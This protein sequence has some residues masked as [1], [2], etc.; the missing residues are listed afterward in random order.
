VKHEEIWH[1]CDRCGKKIKTLNIFDTIKYTRV[2]LIIDRTSEY[3]YS[4]CVEELVDEMD[5]KLRCQT[6]LLNI[7]THSAIHHDTLELCGDCRK[8]FERFMKGK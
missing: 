5:R 1:T 3:S 7:R 6:I 2:P 8:D 4:H